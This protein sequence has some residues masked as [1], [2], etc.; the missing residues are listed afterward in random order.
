[1]NPLHSG[2]LQ[3]LFDFCGFGA[4]QYKSLHFFLFTILSQI[5]PTLSMKEL[6]QILTLW[7]Q[8]NTRFK[9]SHLG[10]F[11]I[12]HCSVALVFEQNFGFFYFRVVI[13][14][15]V[16]IMAVKTLTPRFMSA[17]MQSVQVSNIHILNSP[18]FQQKCQILAIILHLL[19]CVFLC[20]LTSKESLK[21]TFRQR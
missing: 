21:C 9:F 3:S 5:C 15:T 11:Q 18:I 17:L 12:S 4:F 19:D 8:A 1:M 10:Q 14:S 6:L 13:C 2:I 16:N 20:F 7:M